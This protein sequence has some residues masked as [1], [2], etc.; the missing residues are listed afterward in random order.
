MGMVNALGGT[1]P[2][3]T[4]NLFNSNSNFLTESSD[5]LLEGNTLLGIVNSA[6]PDE[7]L[8]SS[9]YRSRNSQ[10]VIAALTQIENQL[11]SLKKRYSADRIGV[12]VGSSTSGISNG[13]LAI[14]YRLLHNT[15]PK[16]FFY[17]QQEMG[18]VAEVVADY[19]G[20]EGPAYVI[21]TACSSSAKVFFSA[22][23]LLDLDLCDAVIVGGADSLCRLTVNGFDAL[24]LVS[25]AH[26]NPFSKNRDGINI[27]EGACFFIMT[28]EVGGIQLLG[29]GESSDAYHMSA[30]DPEAK[31]AV[32]A[33]RNALSNAGCKSDDVCYVNLHGTG[34][35]HND[36]MESKAVHEVFGDDTFC[37][38]TKPMI[39]HMLGASGASEIGI[40]WI[41][42]NEY[43]KSGSDK[44]LPLPCHIWDGV[45]DPQLP[46]L[47]LVESNMTVEVKDKPIVVSN[48]FGFGGGNCAVVLGTEGGYEF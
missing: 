2:E 39:G 20:A 28:R 13:E 24:G 32:S 26:T 46:D 41:A 4:N 43:M 36:S 10:I 45:K 9:K 8:I 6:L 11:T 48:S 38:S 3:I 37:S 35:S 42:L 15:L 22:K 44:I 7:K 12:V 5:Y 40:C 17:S 23:K 47:K 30:P 29:V 19:T 16:D 31:G 18:S 34:T 1:L 33:L 14:E 27:G 25:R 21:S